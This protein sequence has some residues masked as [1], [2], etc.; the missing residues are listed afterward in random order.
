MSKKILYL[1]EMDY[2]I[3][4]STYFMLNGNN[5]YERDFDFA[6]EDS[7]CVWESF[8]KDPEL[9]FIRN[10]AKIIFGSRTFT[11]VLNR[12]I[13]ENSVEELINLDAAEFYNILLDYK[14]LTEEKREYPEIVYAEYENEI[15]ESYMKSDADFIVLKDAIFNTELFKARLNDVLSRTYTIFTE[16]L[17]TEEMQVEIENEVSN[18]QNQLDKDEKKFASSL[19]V[20]SETESEGLPEGLKLCMLHF[21]SQ[22]YIIMISS[23]IVFFG[24]EVPMYVKLLSEGAGT[25]FFIKA[26]SDPTRYRMIKLLA[27]NSYHASELSDI[28][29]FPIS[30]LE[31]HILSIQKA[32]L[33][34]VVK[35]ENDKVYF[36]ISKED[37]ERR[38]D[39]LKKDLLE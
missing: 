8:L 24:R 30:D 16:S 17:Y 31:R 37:L 13:R 33:L 6:T 10:D 11:F 25:E 22:E 32:R 3:S 39:D 2:I 20:F 36:E 14:E 21:A 19:T 18:F 35:G 4:L 34:K 28:L 15:N 9:S 7:S 12:Y 23:M 26:L 29:D 1:P 5:N 38:I 27:G